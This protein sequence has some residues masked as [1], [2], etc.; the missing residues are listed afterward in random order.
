KQESAK[1]P[2]NLQENASKEQKTG[3]TVSFL[4]INGQ[5]CGFVVI[6]DK[7][8]ETSKKAIGRLQEKGIEVIMLT[9]DNAATA[10]AVAAAVVIIHFK[11]EMLPQ[12]KLAEVE[13]LQQEGKK[14]AMAGDGINDAPALAKSNVGIAMGTGTDVA[15]ETADVVLM[16]GD[17]SGVVRAVEVSRRTIRN[18]RQ[19]LFWAFA[20]NTALIPVA[21]GVLYLVWGQSGT[22]SGLQFFFGDFGFLNPMLA[23]LAMAASSLTVVTNSLRLR[24]FPPG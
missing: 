24:G 4:A 14:V 1:I 13:R 8:K 12:D 22:P 9:G 19:N 23:G 15:I 11:A 17:L 5:V 21:A 2:E 10:E 3:K 16:S 20:Y 18:I 7:I 6:G